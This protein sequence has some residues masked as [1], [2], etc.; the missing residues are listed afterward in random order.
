MDKF[1]SIAYTMKYQMLF[2]FCCA[3]FEVP[4]WAGLK[5]NL[6]YLKRKVASFPKPQVQMQ[7]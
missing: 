3:N 6:P 7:W 5:L 4:Y 1:H 2:Q